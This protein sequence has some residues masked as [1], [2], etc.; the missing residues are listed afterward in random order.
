[1][2]NCEMKIGLIHLTIIPNVLF[3]TF[4]VT[5]HTSL[6]IVDVQ[7]LVFIEDTVNRRE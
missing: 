4:G 6:V 5:M 7:M 1:M 3:V 2:I